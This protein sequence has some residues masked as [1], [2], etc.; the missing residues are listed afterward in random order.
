MLTSFSAAANIIT[1]YY[2]WP[3]AVP[4]QPDTIYPC[5]FRVTRKFIKILDNNIPIPRLTYM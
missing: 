2:S 1:T 5:R 3:M 4:L